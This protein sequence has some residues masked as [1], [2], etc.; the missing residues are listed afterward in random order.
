MNEVIK[1]YEKLTGTKVVIRN[2]SEFEALCFEIIALKKLMG[3]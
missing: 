2:E 3:L 1:E